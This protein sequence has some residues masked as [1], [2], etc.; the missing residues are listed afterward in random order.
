MKEYFN[1]E[2][3]RSLVQSFLDRTIDI[4]DNGGFLT[5]TNKAQN[6]LD[7]LTITEFIEKEDIKEAIYSLV[8]EDYYRGINESLEGD[9]EVCAFRVFINH[10]EIY[11]KYG[12]QR[13]GIQI[14]IFSTHKPFLRMNQPFL[15]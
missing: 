1:T 7:Y 2:T 3:N 8:I 5:F 13:E 10:T 14:L 9:F 15:N 6:E 11:L 4:L 12:L